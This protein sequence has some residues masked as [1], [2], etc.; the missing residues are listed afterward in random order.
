[1]QTWN[2]NRF[3]NCVRC[4]HN[5][6]QSRT[7]WPSRRNFRG[8]NS[9]PGHLESRWDW[10]LMKIQGKSTDSGIS[11]SCFYNAEH[12]EGS[13][14]ESSL[15]SLRW[16]AVRNIPLETFHFATSRCLCLS[17]RSANNA[18]VRVDQQ[19]WP[20]FKNHETDEILGGTP[21]SMDLT[22]NNACVAQMTQ[23]L[24]HLR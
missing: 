4:S 21:S 12:F 8:K 2:W 24:S 20:A 15:G 7:W 14:S 3:A 17:R 1:M 5:A 23:R 18:N 9:N 19:L 10:I 6:S 22:K 11:I 13:F 16:A